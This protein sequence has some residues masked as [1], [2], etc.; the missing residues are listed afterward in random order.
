MQPTVVEPDSY[1]F[2]PKWNDDL[3][4][5]EAPRVADF[6]ELHGYV[7]HLPT[8]SPCALAFLLHALVRHEISVSRG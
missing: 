6:V 8:L 3:F 7:S 2:V 5:S 1:I 4:K